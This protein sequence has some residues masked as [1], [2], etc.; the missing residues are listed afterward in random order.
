MR[1]HIFSMQFSINVEG[2]FIQY[3]CEIVTKKPIEVFNKTLVLFLPSYTCLKFLKSLNTFAMGKSTPEK[4]CKIKK[5]V[6]ILIIEKTYKNTLYFVYFFFIKNEY[7][8]LSVLNYFIGI[9][10]TVNYICYIL[11]LFILYVAYFEILV[12]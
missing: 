12:I 4:C 10:C 8:Q 3:F 2:F 9:F 11:T 7:D 6:N 5:L 1:V